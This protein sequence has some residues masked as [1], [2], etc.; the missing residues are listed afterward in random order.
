MVVTIQRHSTSRGLAT[1]TSPSAKAILDE[2]LP[3]VRLIVWSAT[4]VRIA[5]ED[6]EPI[7]C[8]P[9]GHFPVQKP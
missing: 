8:P 9:E 1:T 2:T 5:T 3:V 4:I 7:H 6:R